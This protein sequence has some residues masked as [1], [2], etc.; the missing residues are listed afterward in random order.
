MMR[1]DINI[2]PTPTT[3]T[4]RTTRKG[5]KQQLKGVRF[6][7]REPT[8]QK[9]SHNYQVKFIKILIFMG[10]N[11][12]GE[13]MIEK[14]KTFKGTVYLNLLNVD[15]KATEEDL[16]NLFSD[17][18]IRKMEKTEQRGI[19]LMLVE[20]ANEA[21]KLFSGEERVEILTKP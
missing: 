7:L 13:E 8:P 16:A 19:F 5:N 17:V 3:Q 20:D 10:F 18:K 9:E 14:I 11:K 2:T 15:Y 12:K 4:L 6:R 1:R 21:L